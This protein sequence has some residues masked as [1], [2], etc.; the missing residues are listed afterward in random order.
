MEVDISAVVAPPSKC[1]L[2][3]LND[4]VLLALSTHLASETLTSFSRAYPR[5]NRLI[6]KAHV[7]LQRELHCFFLR[8]PLRCSVLGIG[9]ALDP[10]SR[11]FSSD[12]DWLSM[13][14]F[15]DYRV[16]KSIEKRQFQYFL[17]LAFSRPHFERA[18][19]EIWARLST[20]DKA[21]YDADKDIA[22]RT[23]RPLARSAEPR[24][25][26][27]TVDIIYRMMNNTVVS[28]MRSCNDVYNASNKNFGKDNLLHASEKAVISYCQLFHLLHSLS[29]TE[30]TILSGA[31]ERLRRFI[32]VPEFRIKKHVP[33][34]GELIVLITFVLAS[35]PTN[36]SVIAWDILNGPFLQEAIVRNALWVLK[37]HPE[38]EVMEKGPSDYR[39]QTTFVTSRTSLRLIMFQ[40]T[41]LNVF[42]DAYAKNVSLL[43]DNYGFPEKNIP[44]RVVEAIKEI[45]QVET[46]PAFFRRAQYARG[47][48]FGKEKFSQMLRDAVRESAKRGYHKPKTGGE[49]DRLGRSRARLEAEWRSNARV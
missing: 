3:I 12:F 42:N 13:E 32:Q 30:P 34:L 28:L 49:L 20:L 47:V 44:E 38:L 17:P 45:Y 2:E 5:L 14:A 36:G 15:D 31:A 1:H 25:P 35:P 48:G 21:L 19:E 41:F 6:K 24:R 7:L 22:K 27:H 11:M 46:W 29:R 26:P 39:L 33:D 16:R 43:A 4:D 23:G 10:N 37:D 40:I 8:T 9:V 18:R